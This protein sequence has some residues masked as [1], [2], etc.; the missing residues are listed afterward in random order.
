MI[1]ARGFLYKRENRWAAL[2]GH[3]FLLPR[4]SALQPWSERGERSA[5]PPHTACHLA[6]LFLYPILFLLSY[7]LS[8]LCIKLRVPLSPINLRYTIMIFWRAREGIPNGGFLSL[9]HQAPTG[10]PSGVIA[11]KRLE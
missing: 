7:I 1:S 4:L 6:G 5:T 2:D 3:H 11:K 9:L 8:L 10:L